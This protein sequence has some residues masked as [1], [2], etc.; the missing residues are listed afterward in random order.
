MV[1]ISEEE[2][3]RL[4]LVSSKRN[5]PS[6]KSKYNNQKC[7]FNGL[8]FDSIKERDY[9]LLLLDKQKHGAVR[10]LKRQVKITIQPSFTLPNGKKVREIYYVAD[11]TYIDRRGGYHII[12]VKGGNATKTAVYKLKKK[13]LAYNGFYIE[14]V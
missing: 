4:G 6:K 7:K 1:R 14:E 10:D 11:F 2:A 9:Y 12:D 13:L 8:K 5:K 3:L